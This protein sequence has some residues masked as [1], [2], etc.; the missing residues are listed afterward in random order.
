ML[1]EDGDVSAFSRQALQGDGVAKLT[2]RQALR[3]EKVGDEKSIVVDAGGGERRFAFDVL[4]CAVGR[5]ARLSRFGLA[6]P[7][8]PV[9][10]TV[11]TDEHLQTIYPNILAAGNVAGPCQFTH[12][13]APRPG[14]RRSTVC[15]RSNRWRCCAGGRGSMPGVVPSRVPG[16]ATAGVALAV[17]AALAVLAASSAVAAPPT[18]PPLVDALGGLGA[19]WRVATLPD[20]KP[21]VTRY[22]AE[23]VDGRAALRIEAA[24]SCGNLVHALPGLPA[25]RTLR[26]AWRLQQPNGAADLRRKSGDDAAVKVCLSFDL[27]LAAVPFVERQLLRLARS[28][29]GEALPAATLCWVWAGAE[30]R[31][32]LLDN[33]YSRRVRVIVL[34]NGS[35]AAGAWLQESRDVAADFRRAFGDESPTLPPLTAVIVAGDA[36]NTGGRSVAHVEGLGFGPGD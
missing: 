24:A 34:R 17:A 6:E 10:R 27:P 30:E 21:P 3:C 23:T 9:Q 7:G 19:G 12:T 16:G 31:G 29:S 26:W 15:V 33:V 36:D 13:A 20:Q 25:P 35:D 1:R 28:R 11:V 14:L 22:T 18:L 32:A 5:V 2:D 4:L 8:I